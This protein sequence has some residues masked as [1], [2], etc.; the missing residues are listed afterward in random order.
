MAPDVDRS[1][2]LQS[3]HTDPLEPNSDGRDTPLPL[4]LST[5]SDSAIIGWYPE[6]VASEDGARLVI[7][8]GDT[9]RF[10]LVE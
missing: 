5:P 6:A 4:P 8:G 9:D 1:Y 10:V 2:V 3:V 7:S